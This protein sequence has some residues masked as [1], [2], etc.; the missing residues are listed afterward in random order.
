MTF[1]KSSKKSEQKEQICNI[2]KNQMNSGN[3]RDNIYGQKQTINI[4]GYQ[5]V[6]HKEQKEQFRYICNKCD[7][8]SNNK[9]HYF[10]HLKTKKHNGYSMV[11]PIL[12]KEQPWYICEKCCYKSNKKSNYEK[13]LQTKKHNGYSMVTQKKQEKVSFTCVCGNTYQHKQGLSRHKQHCTYTKNESLIIPEQDKPGNNFQNF[14][15]NEIQDVIQTISTTTIDGEKPV[16][17]III[18]N[19]YENIQTRTNTVNNNT[20]SVKNYLNNDCKDAYDVSDVLD[21]FKCDILKL[22]QKTIPFYKCLIDKIFD[23]P[24]EKLPIRCSDVKRKTF[25]G[26]DEVWI[27]DFDVIKD[28]VMKLVDLVCDL[29]NHYSK[30]NP[31]WHDNDIISDLMHSIIKNIARIYDDTTCKHITNY[32]AEK[33]KIL[34]S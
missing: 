1:R 10:K 4:N 32:I 2:Y 26:K 19:N 11:T 30:C 3:N 5:M 20:F 8:K 18:N 25:F 7:Y 6:T 31:D 28:F 24:A 27:K 21:N 13:H 17:N 23:M 29:R 9:T 14:S 12:E 15:T 16:I 34:K 33:T 22:P